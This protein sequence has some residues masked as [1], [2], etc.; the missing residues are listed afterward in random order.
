MVNSRR[1]LLLLGLLLLGVSLSA[2]ADAGVPMLALAWPGMGLLLI[3]II[4]IE[5]VVLWRRLG[6]PCKQ[7]IGVGT[8][9]NVFTTLIGMP[10]TW[11]GLVALQILSGAGGGVGNFQTP[12]GKIL[13][14]TW[15][16]PW[17]LPYDSDLYWMVPTAM[18]VLLLPFFF[19]S[20]WLEYLLTRRMLRTAALEKSSIRKAVFWANI[21]SYLLLALVS[22]G[23]LVLTLLNHHP[24]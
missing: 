10:L 9:S 12:M 11:F 2:Y 3:P 4:A 16:A 7:A 19:V 21:S 24:G 23:Y 6:I 1:R 17:L 14:V 8:A 18:L 13:A 5:A 22:A 20:W 15:Q